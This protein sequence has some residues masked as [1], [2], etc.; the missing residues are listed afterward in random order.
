MEAKK[1]NSSLHTAHSLPLSHLNMDMCMYFFI[2]S[3]A[4]IN[5]RLKNVLIGEQICTTPQRTLIKVS[6]V[7]LNAWQVYMKP[8][9]RVLSH[10]WWTKVN[11]YRF[12]HLKKK[13][14]FAFQ[15]SWLS[16]C[17]T[18]DHILETNS[19]SE[20]RKQCRSLKPA[21]LIMASRGRLF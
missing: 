9:Y 6:G 17:S 11:N 21:F 5:V 18:V 4:N 19:S 13:S 20:K 15:K 2:C 3:S 7:L 14:S 12:L 8:D 16:R 10:V 1:R